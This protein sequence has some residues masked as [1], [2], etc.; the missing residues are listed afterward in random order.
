MTNEFFLDAIR[1]LYPDAVN[2]VNFLFQSEKM[3]RWD[4][5]VLGNF[6]KKA[7][8]AECVRIHLQ[9]IKREASRRISETGLPWLVERELSGGK[10]IPKDVKSRCAVIRTKCA[11]L[12]KSLPIDFTNDEHWS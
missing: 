6:D 9:L 7:I 1:S 3:V 12:E 11:E 8:D 4:D 10:S 5:D 2:G